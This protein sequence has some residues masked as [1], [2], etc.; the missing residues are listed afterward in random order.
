MNAGDVLRNLYGDIERRVDR[1]RISRAVAQGTQSAGLITIKRPE[2]TVNDLEQYGRLKGFATADQDDLLIME[3]QGGGTVVLGPLQNTAP[4]SYTLDAPLVFKLGIPGPIVAASNAPAAW[5]NACDFLCTGT[6]DNTNI[7]S[8][9]DANRGPVYLSPGTYNIAAALIFRR[10]N[11]ALIGAG[12]DTIL[13]AATNLN[14]YVIASTQPTG[15]HWN[16]CRVAELKIDGNAA[17][18]S[19]GGGIKFLGTYYA[20][21]DHVLIWNPHDIGI[22]LDR[23]GGGNPYGA[24]TFIDKC[25]IYGGALG[26]GVTR[27]AYGIQTAAADFNFIRDT[28]IDWF[29]SVGGIGINLGGWNQKLNN[30]HVDECETDLLLDFVETNLI[31][32]CSFDRPTLRAIKQ[33]GGRG[34]KLTNCMIG[35]YAGSSNNTQPAVEITAAANENSYELTFT[36][37]NW[38]YGVQEA[39]GVG[40]N[41]YIACLTAAM[42]FGTAATNFLGT[43][44]RK[45]VCSA[46]F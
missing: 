6:A 23:N 31:T 21:I 38:K 37:T 9:L 10:D 30:V 16:G 24:Y 18:Q 35:T 33:N 39:V 34:N 46:N 29:N 28:S 20:K 27:T 5:T 3:T 1:A 36:G 26:S 25:H 19:S 17:N 11:A 42:T 2:S 22:L 13:R 45:A 32:N 4:T 8:A 14:D 15:D 12:W 44:P 40:V 41:S 7:Q 43:A